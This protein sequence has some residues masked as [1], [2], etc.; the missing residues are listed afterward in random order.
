MMTEPVMSHTMS[1]SMEMTLKGQRFIVI[2]EGKTCELHINE[3]E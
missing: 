1:N 3:E 2:K